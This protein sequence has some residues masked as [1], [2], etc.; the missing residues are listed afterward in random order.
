MDFLG[1][2]LLK[3]GFVYFAGFTHRWS[4]VAHTPK[5]PNRSELL[6]NT[7]ELPTI[8]IVMQCYDNN[9]AI[10]GFILDVVFF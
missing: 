8:T 2:S 3:I 5:P 6:N 7:L 10:S 4:D 1:Y 9:N